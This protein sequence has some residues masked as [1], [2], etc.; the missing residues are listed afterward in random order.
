MF[1]AKNKALE[2]TAEIVK[3]K[4]ANST[5]SSNALGGKDVADFFKE[6]YQGVLEVAETV[7]DPE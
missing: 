7:S 1:R 2:I 6:I 3:A 4:M 5:I